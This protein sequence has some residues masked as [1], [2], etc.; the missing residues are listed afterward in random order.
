M[1]EAHNEHLRSKEILINALNKHSL[2]Y[3]IFNLDELAINNICYY[4]DKCPKSGL[5]PKLKL[6]IS[7]GGDGTLLH[8]SHHVGGDVLLL[9]INSCPAHSVGHMCPITPKFTEK[10]IDCFCGKAIFY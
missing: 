2:S 1:Q 6:V 8:A 5:R 10:T 3:K 9:G 4:D 7:L